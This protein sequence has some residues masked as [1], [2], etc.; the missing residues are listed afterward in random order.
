MLLNTSGGVTG[1]DRFTVEAE[2]ESTARLTLTTQAAERV[3]RAQPGETGRVDTRLTIASGGRIDW[4]PQETIVFERSSL[5]RRLRVDMAPDATLL[6]VEPLVF[7]RRAM[8]EV[9]NDIRLSD[10]IEIHRD[11][12]RILTDATRLDGSV[13][14]VMKGAAT[15]DGATALATVILAAPGAEAFL[16]NVRDLLPAAA[17]ASVIRPDLLFVRILAEDSFALRAS[18]IPVISLLHRAELPRTWML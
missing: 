7:G 1:G 3:Y 13:P 9:L 17:G 10:R 15:G 5:R 2:A 14:Q 18:L 8:G 11:D 12:E 16:D 4:L 6:L